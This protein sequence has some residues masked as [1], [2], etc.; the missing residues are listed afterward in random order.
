MELEKRISELLEKGLEIN[1][2]KSG[3]ENIRLRMTYNSFS[4]D[5]VI[6]KNANYFDALKALEMRCDPSLDDFLSK[7]IEIKP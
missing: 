5:I 1:F 6:N 2:R 3:D 4:T 7:Y